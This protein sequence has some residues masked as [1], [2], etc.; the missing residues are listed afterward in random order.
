MIE[1]IIYYGSLPDSF[2]EIFKTINNIAFPF[3][4]EN[5]TAIE[6]LFINEMVD[7]SIIIYTNHINVR[8]VGIFNKNKAEAF[9]GFW[10]TINDIAINIQAFDLLAKDAKFFNCNKIEGPINFNTYNNYRLSTKPLPSW[11]WFVGEPINA[12]Y[13][14]SLLE[15]LGYT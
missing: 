4:N 2:F 8:L 1:R 15:N 5:S 12:I 6:E 3:L 10:E 7:S 11:G 14:N 9:F 13:Y